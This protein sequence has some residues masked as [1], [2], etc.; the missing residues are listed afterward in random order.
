MVHLH[1]WLPPEKRSL[2]RLCFCT[3]LSVILFTGG[4]G[5][6]WQWGREWGNLWQGACMAGG[7]AWQGEHVRGAMCG[8]RG[9]R[10]RGSMCGRGGVCVAG[11]MC[12]RGSMHGRGHVWQ[13]MHAPAS[14]GIPWDTVNERAVRILL[15]CT[16]VSW[17]IVIAIPWMIAIFCLLKNK[18]NCKMDS[19]AI[20]WLWTRFQF[21]SWKRIAIAK[22]IIF[23][24]RT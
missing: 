17:A 9:M 8:G 7:C 19:V 20:L 6:A 1:L 15:E 22:M 23:I 21:M 11:G 13:G 18:N 16:L 14:P 2:R 3:C 12:G 4:G 5:H 24:T 10:G